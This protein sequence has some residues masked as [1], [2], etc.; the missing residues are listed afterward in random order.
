MSSTPR[1]CLVA[2]VDDGKLVEVWEHIYDLHEF[3]QFYGAGD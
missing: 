2:R 3:D 1:I